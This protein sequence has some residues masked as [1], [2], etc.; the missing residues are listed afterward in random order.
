MAEIRRESPVQFQGSPVKTEMR[1]DWTVALAYTD[2]GDGPWLVDLS[3]K[4]RWDLQDQKYRCDER[5]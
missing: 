1:D 3:H 2:E 5:R 4:T